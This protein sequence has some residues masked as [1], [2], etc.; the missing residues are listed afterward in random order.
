MD[1]FLTEGPLRP[2]DAVAAIIALDDG[3]YLMQLRDQKPNLFYP[4]HWGLFGGAIEPGENPEAALG[5]ELVEE[6]GLK[7]GPIQYFTDFTFDYGSYG[8]VFRRF[9]EVRIASSVFGELVLHEGAD[10]RLFKASEILNLPRVV[11]YDSFAIWLHA[12][13]ALDT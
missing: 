9:Y 4:G 10:M 7:A 12:S 3:R 8:R 11:P 13:G 5:R 1:F 2:S 6:I